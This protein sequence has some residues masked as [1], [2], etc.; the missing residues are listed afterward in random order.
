MANK[1]ISVVGTVANKLSSL[2]IRDGQIIFVKDKKRV[3]L[4]LDG[5]RTFY[6]QIELL[7]KEQN[8]LDLLA[9][10]NGCFYFVIDTAVLWFYQDNWV[11]LTTTPHD[12]VFF[13][14]KL[15]EL[16]QANTLYVN[17]ETGNEGIRVWDDKTNAYI[18]IADKTN[19]MS[20]SDVIALFN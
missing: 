20:T 7:D 14:T 1:M 11:Q 17:K 13:G 2:P 15:P 10:V 4:D 6:N 12:V 5:K 18:T 3:A 19:S 9:P 8:R 16:G